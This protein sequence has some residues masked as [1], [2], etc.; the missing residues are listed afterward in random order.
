MELKNI[1]NAVASLNNKGGKMKKIILILGL[2][3][4]CG[5]IF[6]AASCSWFG[7]KNSPT[8]TFMPGSD[9]DAHGCI[10]SAGYSWCEAKQKCLRVWEEACN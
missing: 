7:Q 3:T 9:R 5:F 4:V 1:K 6:T 8:A 2:L 10:A